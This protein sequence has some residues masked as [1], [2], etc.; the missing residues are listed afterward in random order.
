MAV[1]AQ[2]KI[3]S[4]DN[5]RFI[6]VAQLAN[7]G[8]YDQEMPQKFHDLDRTPKNPAVMGG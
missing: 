1:P 2:I 6:T 3:N 7:Y 5:R 8:C 4:P